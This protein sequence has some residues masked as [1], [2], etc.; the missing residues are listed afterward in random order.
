M[1]IP[2]ALLE[3][4]AGLAGAALKEE[5]LLTPKP[6][7]VDCQDQGAHTDM[8]AALFLISIEALQP[9][10]LQ[11]IVQGYQSK[12]AP[13]KLFQQIREIGKAAERAMFQATNGI[14][15]HK[16]AQF[17][18]T[19]SHFAGILDSAKTDCFLGSAAK[20]SDHR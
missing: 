10:F 1:Q 7:L 13:A 20:T 8:D 16:G 2:V 9:F 19:D 3:H 14:N 5:V 4:I 17:F 12:E 15:T 18:G 6:G 11:Y